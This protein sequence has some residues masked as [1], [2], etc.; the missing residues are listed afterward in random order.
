[1][2]SFLTGI[3]LKPVIIKFPGLHCVHCNADI[4]VENMGWEDSIMV[5]R[6][7]SPA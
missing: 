1:M 7:D 6:K 5:M 3:A 4:S 2:E